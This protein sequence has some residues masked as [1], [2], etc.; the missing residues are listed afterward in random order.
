MLMNKLHFR[1]STILISAG[2]GILLILFSILYDAPPPLNIGV[3]L[4]SLAGIMVGIDAILRKKIILRSQYHRR[5]SETYLGIAAVAQGLIVVFTACFL[6]LLIVINYL[7]E[8]RNLFQHFVEHPSV[9]L[10]F[11]SAICI[12][13]AIFI[14]V[15]SVE[16]KQGS[17]FTIVLNLLASRLLPSI[18]LM[19]LG[20]IIFC[21][22][23]LE[24]I[25]PQYFDSLGGGFIEHLFRGRTTS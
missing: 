17:K 22:G 9:P 20:I 24:I 4:F 1:T 5:L 12:L 2:L 23:I 6:I 13:S 25:N 11:V 7:N 19:L 15:G 18:I 21:L 16:D 8:G 3:I 10:L 14:S